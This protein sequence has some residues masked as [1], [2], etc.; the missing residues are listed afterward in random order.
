MCPSRSVDERFYLEVRGGSAGRAG[1]TS[2]A[3]AARRLGLHQD[4]PRAPRRS[5][6]RAQHLVSPMNKVPKGRRFAGGEEV[7]Q[8]QKRSKAPTLRSSN[9]V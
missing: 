9:T 7:A 3:A 1:D 4:D 5:L 6:A 2:R 8:R